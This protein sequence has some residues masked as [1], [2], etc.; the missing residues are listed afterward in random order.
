MGDKNVYQVL[1]SSLWF[2]HSA[3]IYWEPSI[4]LGLRDPAVEKNNQDLDLV[5]FIF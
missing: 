2:S 5:K 4:I 1:D 3:A